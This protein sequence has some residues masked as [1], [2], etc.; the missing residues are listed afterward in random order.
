MRHT[1]RPRFEPGTDQIIP[2]TFPTEGRVG[3]LL[4]LLTGAVRYD[5]N[6]ELKRIERQKN[7]ET[8]AN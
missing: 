1:E 8:Y 2:F 5:D 3:V 6:Q 4:A 7:M